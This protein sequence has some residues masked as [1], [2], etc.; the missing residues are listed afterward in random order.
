MIK[1][2]SAEITH[3]KTNIDDPI[4][5]LYTFPIQIEVEG[6]IISYFNFNAF[7]VNFQ[8]LFFLSRMQRE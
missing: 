8:E 5:F 3:P 4:I 6:I 7:S 2:A 1:K